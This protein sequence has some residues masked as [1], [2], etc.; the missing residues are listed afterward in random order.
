MAFHE[1]LHFGFSESFQ[2]KPKPRAT[3]FTSEAA[4]DTQN[5]QQ[6]EAESDTVT[7][8]RCGMISILEAL[9]VKLPDVFA[10]EILP[11]L[12]V[13]DTLS[14]AQVNKAYNA[15]VW[16]ADGVRSM[17]VKIK[18]HFGEQGRIVKPLYWAAKH[19]NVPAV[20]ARLESGE[21][22]YKCLT[23][24]EKTALHIAG[25]YGH[26]AVVKALIEAGADV[27]KRASPR[28]VDMSGKRS[29]VHNVTPVYYAAQEGHTHVVME[30]IKAGADVNQATSQGATPLYTAAYRGHEGIV[31]LLIQAGADVRKADKDGLTPMKIATDNKR[32]KV[33]TLLKFYERV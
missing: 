28:A 14:L 15:A 33:V 16:S 7:Y 20:R 31:A 13:K 8:L 24:D 1:S 18:A 17:E 26:A 9:S 12:D 22:V 29:V 27:N 25:C 2:Q 30:L 6:E 5:V 32:E 3:L 4:M 19:G 11:R 10:A 21:D 23:H